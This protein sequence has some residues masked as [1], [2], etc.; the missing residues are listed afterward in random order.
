MSGQSFRRYSILPLSWTC[1]WT[2]GCT[3]EETGSTT[4]PASHVQDTQAKP[5][6]SKLM[7]LSLLSTKP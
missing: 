6:S 2:P 5:C 3:E 1:V 4:Q 7:V